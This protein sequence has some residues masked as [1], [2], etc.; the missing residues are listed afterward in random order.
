M[1]VKYKLAVKNGTYM[2]G[3][4]KNKWLNVGVVM[5][6]DYGF[7]MLLDKTF[8]PAGVQGDDS[9]VIVSMFE[10]DEQQQA[11]APAPAPTNS[12]VPF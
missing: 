9:S 11:P 3:V 1:S 6:N 8:N 7:F 2:D 5:Q 4:E 12:D 10:P